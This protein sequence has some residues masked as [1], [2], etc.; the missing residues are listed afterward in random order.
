[1]MSSEQIDAIPM[2]SSM[3]P[4]FP[5]VPADERLAPKRNGR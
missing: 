1:M 5:A 4:I 3:T 2:L